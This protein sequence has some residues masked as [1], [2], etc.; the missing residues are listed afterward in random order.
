MIVQ[1]HQ[2]L[3]DTIQLALDI[4]GIEQTIGTFA[5]AGNVIISLLRAASDKEKDQTRK[6]LIDAGLSAISMI[7]FADFVKLLKFRKL[8]KPAVAVARTI[9][10]GAKELPK[11]YTTEHMTKSQLKSVVKDIVR[12]SITEKINEAGEQIPKGKLSQLNPK[13]IKKADK[14][15]YNLPPPKKVNEAGMTSEGDKKWIQKAVKPSH[16][17]Y[18]TPMTKPTCTP[19]RKALAMRFKKGIEK[20]QV[21]EG[22]PQYKVVSPTQARC[23]NCNP[24]LNIQCDPEMTEEKT[25]IPVESG[26]NSKMIRYL[27]AMANQVEQNPKLVKE[28][29]LQ[30]VDKL[31]REGEIKENYKV[32]HRSAMTVKDTSNDPN[33]VRDPEIPYGA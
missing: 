31:E 8:R 24:A 1:D 21:N 5:D 15:K 26:D 29:L 6:H 18:C 14:G 20:E 11:S 30:L 32:Q 25:N 33:N 2:K 12:E 16:K 4:A 27:K 17:G 10:T 3:L 7:P 13:F 22:G 9:K 19:R 28:V 23:V